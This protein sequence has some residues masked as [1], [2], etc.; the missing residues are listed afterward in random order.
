M[1]FK[2]NSR[3]RTESFRSGWRSYRVLTGLLLLLAG[4]CSKDQYPATPDRLTLQQTISQ[5]TSLSLLSAAIK[6]SGVDSV[7]ATGGPYTVFAATNNAFRAAGL[8]ADKINAYDPQ[9]L[10]NIIAYQVLAGRIGS[11]TVTGF[12]SDTIPSLNL[13]YSPIITQNYYGLFINGIKVTQGNTLMA[14]GILHKMDQIAFPPVGNLLQTLDSLP[15]TRMAAYIYHRSMALRAFAT[16]PGPFFAPVVNGQPGWVESVGII[17]NSATLLIPSDAAFKALGYNSTAD[18][19]A[20]DSLSRTNLIANCTMFGSY[21]TSDFMGGRWVGQ[22]FPLMGAP[23]KTNIIGFG[24]ANPAYFDGQ[25][26][27][28]YRLGGGGAYEIGNDGL[29]L[30]GYGVLTPPMI[31]KPNIVTTVGVI[32]LIDQVF[33]PVTNYNPGQ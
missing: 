26:F 19:A 5:D 7:L 28:Q 3:C 10:R 30:Y 29:S 31:I 9:Q 32:H 13:Q 18:L 4:S 25:N 23:G 21:F 27:H 16:D 17:K 12:I 2:I 20:L 8:T 11:A 15:D 22:T 24:Q 33:A 1:D 14:D 6:R